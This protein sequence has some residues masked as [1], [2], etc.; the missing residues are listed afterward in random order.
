[1]FGLTFDK[2]LLIGIIAVILIG[3][4]SLP[5]YAAALAKTVRGLRLMLD[6]A[7]ERLREE[8]GPEFDEVDWKH[9]DPRQYD[10]RSIIREALLSDDRPEVGTQPASVEASPTSPVADPEDDGMYR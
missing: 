2:L 7:K 6:S 1:M 10:P 3:P 8:I 4:E 9:L 5:R